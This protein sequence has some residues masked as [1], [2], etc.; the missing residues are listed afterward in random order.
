MTACTEDLAEDTAVR[1]ISEHYREAEVKLAFALC[2]HCDRRPF[3]RDMQQLQGEVSALHSGTTGVIAFY[4]PDEYKL[5]QNEV[6]KLAAGVFDAKAEEFISGRRQFSESTRVDQKTHLEGKNHVKNELKAVTESHLLTWLDGQT[7]SDNGAAI[8]ARHLLRI[9]ES[10]DVDAA[11]SN[12][13]GLLA[14]PASR[15]A[16]GVVRADLYYNWRCAN[17]GSNS[18][19][20]V[21]DLYHVLNAS[22]CDIYL[23]AEAAQTEYASLIL[24]KWTVVTIYDGQTPIDEW[25][26]GLV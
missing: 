25:L 9:Y 21:D 19:D 3:A 24:S 4:G 5:L 18:K 23:T 15:V 26:L 8:L 7:P 2:S 12:A 22:Y 13:L 14:I 17:R 1:K 16:K 11:V 10:T 20:L 6:D